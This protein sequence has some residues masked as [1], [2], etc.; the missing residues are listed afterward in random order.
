MDGKWDKWWM[1]LLVPAALAQVAWV[2]LAG[3]WRKTG[4]LMD[5]TQELLDGQR[6][7]EAKLDALL[8]ALAEDDEEVPPM[9]LD[10]DLTPPARQ[11]H[12]PL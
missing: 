1:V 10:G 9:T 8:H 6:R 3:L 7:I 11:E 5:T 2:K 4:R 12:T